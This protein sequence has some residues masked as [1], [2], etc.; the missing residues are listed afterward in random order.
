LRATESAY[1]IYFQRNGQ[2]HH[3]NNG[4]YLGWQHA[5]AVTYEGLPPIKPGSPI[6]TTRVDDWIDVFYLTNDDR[7]CQVQCNPDT[8]MQH[9]FAQFVA[10][11]GSDKNELAVVGMGANID[12]Y[13]LRNNQLFHSHS[14]NFNGW[15]WDWPQPISESDAIYGLSAVRTK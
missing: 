11:P 6:R 10:G 9:A 5:P 7:I 13:Y 12:V 3:I 4:D 8:G 1:D 14:G 15:T 2:L